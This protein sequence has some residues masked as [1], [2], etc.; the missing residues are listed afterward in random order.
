MMCPWVV[1]TLV[2]G[3]ILFSGVPFDIVDILCFFI[4]NPKISHFHRSRSLSFDSVVCNSDGC[5]VIAM[6]QCFWLGMAQLFEG[7]SK[8]HALFTIQEEGA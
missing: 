1:F 6:D 2:V 3:K 7:Q 8:N 4:A 5:G